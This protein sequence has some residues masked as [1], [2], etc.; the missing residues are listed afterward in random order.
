MTTTMIQFLRA[1]LLAAALVAI[2]APGLKATDIA[3]DQV[4]GGGGAVSDSQYTLSYSLGSC[5]AGEAASP[6]Y[7]ER[8]GF[9][10]FPLAGVTGVGPDPQPPIP[11]K[12]SFYPLGPTLFRGE[13]RLGFSLAGSGLHPVRIC[14]L[15]VQGRVRRL[16]RSSSLAAGRYELTW[17]GRDDNG[18]RLPTGLYWVRMTSDVPAKVL[19]LLLLH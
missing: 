6:Q 8:A 1:T 18:S 9:W 19:R 3:R 14:A 5:P 10:A 17:D 13:A 7:I 11:L 2:A 4:S 16:L 12:T 15:D